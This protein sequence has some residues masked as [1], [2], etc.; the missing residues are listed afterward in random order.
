MDVHL[1]GLKNEEVVGDSLRIRQIY[2]NILSN[3]A[4]Y[5]RKGGAFMWR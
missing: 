4:K 2:I 3:A 1:K 5:T